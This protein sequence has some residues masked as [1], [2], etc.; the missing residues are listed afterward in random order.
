MLRVRSHPALPDDP[1]AIEFV[2][3]ISAAHPLVFSNWREEC[4]S[5]KETAY[6]STNI[7][8]E[9]PLLHVKGP[10]AVKLLSDMC[11]NNIPATKIG[12]A[13]HAIAC[14]PAGNIMSEGMLLRFAEDDFGCY[15]LNPVVTY[16][17]NSGKYDVEP[18]EFREYDYIY[19]VGGPLSLQIL[20]QAAE[21]DLHDIGF[22]RFRNATIAG[23]EVRIL[24]MGMAGTLGYEVHGLLEDDPDLEVYQRIWEVGAPMGLRKL[25]YTSYTYDHAENGFPQSGIHY[26]NAWMDW[27]EMYEQLKAGKIAGGAPIA[28]EYLPLNGSYA[29]RD[30]IKHEDYY[31]NPF[32]TG[33]AHSINWKHDFMGKEAL[34]A[35]KEGPHRVPAT[36]TWDVED[37][38]DITRSLYETD[39][40]PYKD[41]VYPL[42][43]PLEGICGTSQYQV[44]DA[45]GNLVGRAC[46]PEYS[47]TYRKLFSFAVVNEDAAVQ[48]NEFTLVWGNLDDRKK[49]VRVRVDRYPLLD[50]ERNENVDVETIPHFQK[51]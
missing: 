38:L 11:V 4:R 18:I 7:S 46:L 14:S 37:V 48:G 17:A 35:L 23:H 9:C 34:L 29:S 15:G 16:L 45:E 25:G 22:M 33:Q 51:Q 24:R 42:A 8:T 31:C 13:K 12:T 30:G 2:H 50:M 3:V 43:F 1:R 5:W 40:E 39:A 41:L 49:N 10:D 32:E 44:L 21:E 28:I 19:Q 27:P 26:L 47:I 6:L 20:E 36:L